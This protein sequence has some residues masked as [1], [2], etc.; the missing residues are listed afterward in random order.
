MK[1]SSFTKAV[2]GGAVAT[3]VALGI[4][5]P[6]FA[7]LPEVPEVQ[8]TISNKEAAEQKETIPVDSTN[9]DAIVKKAQEDGYEVKVNP[10]KT[11]EVDESTVEKTIT[12]IQADYKTQ[13][14]TITNGTSKYLD[15]YAAYQEQL[16]AY[17]YFVEQQTTGAD[18]NQAIQ[19]PDQLAVEQPFTINDNRASVIQPNGWST[20]ERGKDITEP[21]TGKTVVSGGVAAYQSDSQYLVIKNQVNNGQSYT[22]TWKNAATDKETGRSLDAT[23]V[24][25]DIVVGK[26]GDTSGTG[27]DDTVPF[28]AAY[29]N[30][31]DNFLINGITSMKQ[32]LTYSYSDNG[33]PYDKQFY[34]TFGSLN[35]QGNSG[36]RY[37]FAAPGNGVVATFL[38]Q[39]SWVNPTAQNVSGSGAAGTQ[40]AFMLTQGQSQKHGVVDTSSGALTALGVTFLSNNGAS[41]TVGVSGSN[42]REA[43]PIQQGSSTT[44]DQYVRATYNHIMMSTSTVA[45]TAVKPV[46]P[47]KPTFEV[48][49]TVVQV[50]KPVTEKEADGAGKKVLPGQKTTQRVS[51]N[52]GA[53]TLKDFALGDN[54][55]F[56]EDGRNP[57]SVDPNTLKVTNEA[58]EDVTDQFAITTGDTEVDGEKVHQIIA[59]AKDPASLP[60]Y[61]DYT[62]HV[63]QTALEDGEVDTQVDAGFSVR[64]GEL[65]YTDRFEYYEPTVEPHKYDTAPKSYIDINTKTAT[66]GDVLQYL[67]VNDTTDLTDTVEELTKQGIVDKYD[68]KNGH[69]NLDDVKVYQ[70]PGDVDGANLASVTDVLKAGA[71]DVTASF[72]INDGKEEGLS[73]M[74]KT[75]EDGKLVL[76]MGYKYIVVMPYTVTTNE[77]TNIVNG[78][79]QINNEWVLETERVTNPL[80]KVQPEKDVVVKVGDEKSID[81]TEIAIKTVFN[82]ELNSSTRPA[83]YGNDTT[84]WS[85][86]DDYDETH[87]EYTGQYVVRTQHDFVNAEGETVKAGTDVSQYFEQTIDKETGAVTYTANQDY[88]DLMNLPENKKTEQGWTAWMQVKRIAYADEVKNVFTENINGT[89]LDSNE[90]VTSTP[91]PPKPGDPQKPAEPDN[92]KVNTG[93]QTED[94]SGLGYGIAGGGLLALLGGLAYGFRNKFKFRNKDAN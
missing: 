41:Y 16:K 48:T 14:D 92:P 54:I 85:I 17:N 80:V 76:P 32:T 67:I 15:D 87:D 27:H 1:N 78:A 42:G 3:T 68:T 60:E 50:A 33:S 69:V 11:V 31:S 38:N 40:R 71:E 19:S 64:N 47:A 57:V 62:L 84:S 93:G 8:N 29:S 30:F 52:T 66:T 25:S 5:S 45:P 63:Q 59:V 2:C 23:I 90:V 55:F 75:D 22:I 56:T 82:Y 44:G 34:T 7:N 74:M 18:P 28:I 49:K 37:E 88:L 86:H 10:D 12:D 26:A 83:N 36:Q 72:D 91:E 89:E 77:A 46:E 6:A 81:G 35:A 39:E 51:S 53:G 61:E 43:L 13:G 24:V 79:S 4:M 65:Q 9:L 73:V 20:L 21:G 58:D 70:L 94:N